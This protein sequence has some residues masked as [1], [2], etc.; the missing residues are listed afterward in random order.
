MQLVPGRHRRAPNAA[1]NGAQKVT[2][3]WQRLLGQ[4]ELEN[5]RREVPRALLVHKGR[6][7]SITVAAF[8]VAV[9]ASALID[10]FAIG[11]PFARSW[12]RGIRRFECV[13]LKEVP[14]LVAHLAMFPEIRDE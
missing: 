8:R 5:R 10:V 1:C 13:R 6:S 2:I 14:P 4:P 7:R 11:D 12:R 3:G 9:E